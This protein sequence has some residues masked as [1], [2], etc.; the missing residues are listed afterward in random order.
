MLSHRV[1]HCPKII[2]APFHPDLPHLLAITNLTISTVLLFLEWYMVGIIHYSL[3]DWLLS[4]SNMYLIFL[5]VFLWLD[6]A[7]FFLT[8]N[9]IPLSGC[10]TV[11]LSIPL[12]KDIF[13]FFFFFFFL[14]L[15]TPIACGGFPAMGWTQ[16]VA[17][18]LHP[19]P[20]QRQVWATQ[21]TATPDP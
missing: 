10:T 6:I 11:Y 9:N 5:Q 14:F 19:Q 2:C 21:L 3:S 1:L 16:A 18:R 8:L 4:L 13:F 20:Q 15:N 12:L 7:H 17:P